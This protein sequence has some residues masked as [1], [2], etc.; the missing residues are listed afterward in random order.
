[1]G[2]RQTR[3]RGVVVLSG[4]CVSMHAAN[5]AVAV[6]V[7]RRQMIR[8]VGHFRSVLLSLSRRSIDDHF[9]TDTMFFVRFVSRFL[10]STLSIIYGR[11][12]DDESKHPTLGRLFDREPFIRVL[13]DRVSIHKRLVIL[14]SFSRVSLIFY[15]SSALFALNIR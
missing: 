1:M 6:A 7:R 2:Q 11:T 15:H 14:T 13:A 10:R 3:Y 8:T 4:G 12:A 5:L 9:F